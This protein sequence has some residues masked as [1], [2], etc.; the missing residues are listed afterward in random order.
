MN[1]QEIE[2]LRIFSKLFFIAELREKHGDVICFF[3]KVSICFEISS[4]VDYIHIHMFSNNVKN[5][6]K[7]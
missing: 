2:L 3:D 7:P 6:L 5:I 4:A 1:L